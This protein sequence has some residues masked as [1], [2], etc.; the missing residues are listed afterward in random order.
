MP[1]FETELDVLLATIRKMPDFIERRTVEGR[2]IY[3]VPNET[4]QGENFA[5]RW[6]TEPARVKAFCA[7]HAAALADFQELADLHGLDRITVNLQKSLGSAPVRRVM[8]NRTDV[9]GAARA[10]SKLFIAPAVGLTLAGSANAAPVPRNT[11][12]GD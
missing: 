9:I 10:A 1:A 7:W 4:T 2:L 8:D 12:F 3:W 5:D 6:N 11:H